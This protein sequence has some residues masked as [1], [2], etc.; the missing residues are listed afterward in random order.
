MGP[1]SGRKPLGGHYRFLFSEFWILGNIDYEKDL[2]KA[3]W[4][5]LSPWDVELGAVEVVS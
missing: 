5:K 2:M 4:S 1:A 3:V